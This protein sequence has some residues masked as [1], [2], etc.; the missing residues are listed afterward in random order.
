MTEEKP[1]PETQKFSS[2]LFAAEVAKSVA[3]RRL[4]MDFVEER[5]SA[6]TEVIDLIAKGEKLGWSRA[7]VLRRYVDLLDAARRE[8]FIEALTAR[9]ERAYDTR[10]P[11]TFN[12]RRLFIWAR[13]PAN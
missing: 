4:A 1:K 9:L 6:R 8:P 5:Y 13:R 10:G 11:L 3:E 7:T 12:F 2:S